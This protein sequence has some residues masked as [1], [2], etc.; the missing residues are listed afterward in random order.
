M[1]SNLNKSTSCK[2]EGDEGIKKVYISLKQPKKLVQ[3]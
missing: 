3:R 2:N 1:T